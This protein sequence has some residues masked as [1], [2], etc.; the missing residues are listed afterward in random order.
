MILLLA[1]AAAIHGAPV[2]FHHAHYRVGDP[3][4]A[5]SEAAARLNGTRTI[6]SGLGVGVRTGNTYVLF[7]R[8]ND[9]DERDE[10]GAGASEGGGPVL[11]HVGFAAADFDAV[12]A[13]LTAV[14]SVVARGSESVLFDAGTFR[15]EIVRETDA[16]E[17]FWCPMHPDVRTPVAGKCP[18]CAMDL[19]A[20]PPMRIGEYKLD[21]VLRRGPR[22]GVSGL[23]LTVREPHTNNR[24]TDFAIVHE[25]TFHL[26]IVSRDLEYF[27]HLHPEQQADGSFAMKHPLPPG[28]FML[29]ADFLPRDGSPQMVQRAIMSPGLARIQPAPTP[30][31]TRSPVVLVEG[32]RFTLTAEDLK[33]GRQACLTVRLTDARTGEAITDLEPFLGAPAHIL[34][35]RADL[36]DAVHGHPEES[37]TAGPSVSFHPLI[38]ADGDY[39]VWIQVQRSGRVITAPFWLRTGR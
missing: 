9:R 36:G 39:K 38:P 16:P 27:R 15:I 7:D 31:A 1:L 30:A 10:G 12:V 2:R 14:H 17:A 6:V 35:V 23:R 20:I 22:V 26:F 28:E 5:M 11:H 33:P 18:V 3:A 21:V 19:A 34:M 32:T 8:H 25:K 37:A 29:L 24:V 4:A 13:R